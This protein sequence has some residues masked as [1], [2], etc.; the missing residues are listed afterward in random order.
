MLDEKAESSHTDVCVKQTDVCV[1]KDW[2]AVGLAEPARDASCTE[3]ARAKRIDL[4][5]REL[6]MPHPRRQ[7][8]RQR[9]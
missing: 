6:Q 3:R 1:G 5:Q 8:H 7:L 2:Q 9:L 4:R